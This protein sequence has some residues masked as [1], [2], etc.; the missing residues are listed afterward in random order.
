MDLISAFKSAN[1]KRDLNKS[2]PTE[3]GQTPACTKVD[4]TKQF[5]IF[6]TKPSC[7]K[8]RRTQA[9]NGD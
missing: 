4:Q 9:A 7:E 3:S 2:A 1:Y 6:S 8:E 5:L